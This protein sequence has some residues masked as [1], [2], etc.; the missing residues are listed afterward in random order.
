MSDLFL[1]AHEFTLENIEYHCTLLESFCHQHSSESPSLILT[2]I[3]SLATSK[4]DHQRWASCLFM[5][6]IIQ[7]YEDQSKDKWNAWLSHLLGNIKVRSVG[8]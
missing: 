3:G 6:I 2:K 1:N 7:Y 5:R 4:I 8:V